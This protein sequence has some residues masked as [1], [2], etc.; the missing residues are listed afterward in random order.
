MVN[1]DAGLTIRDRL[2][3]MKLEF[4]LSTPDN[5]DI[6]DEL[7]SMGPEERSKVA[8]AMM[9]TGRYIYGGGAGGMNLDINSAL[10]SFLTSEINNIASGALKTMDISFGMETYDDWG[11]ARRDFSFQFAKRFYNDRI[12]VMVG[13]KVSTSNEQETESFLDNVSAEYRL[14]PSGTKN[15]K[16]FHE[17]NYESLLEGEITKTGA[18]IMFRKKVRWLREL[19][20]FR[21]KKAEP[22][23]DDE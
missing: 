19:F 5:R 16:L 13:G 22:V 11:D 9:A 23:P 7:V 1:F 21:K 2:N 10:N 8:L 18:G 4:L 12:R 15:V 14:D 20:D 17:R 6:Q 3:S